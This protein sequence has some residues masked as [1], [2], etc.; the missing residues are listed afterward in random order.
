MADCNHC[1]YQGVRPQ[2]PGAT[3]LELDTLLG[4]TVRKSTFCHCMV[5]HESSTRPPVSPEFAFQLLQ[6][7][8][9]SE[10]RHI[11]THPKQQHCEE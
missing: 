10:A 5:N 4:V 9:H 2:P 1:R 3:E 11:H 6:H 8:I 7:S